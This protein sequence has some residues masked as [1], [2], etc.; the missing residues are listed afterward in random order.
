MYDPSGYLD[1][2]VNRLTIG[3]EAGAV[4]FPVRSPVRLLKR[5]QKMKRSLYHKVSQKLSHA[6]SR[7]LVHSS[8]PGRGCSPNL[9]G[10]QGCSGPSL[11]GRRGS[12]ETRFNPKVLVNKSLPP[13][14]PLNHS[15]L[16]HTR[17]FQTASRFVAPRRWKPS[18]EFQRA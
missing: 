12:P 3:V 18:F 16:D 4:L 2:T 13:E 15:L 8:S 6:L 7:T 1:L 9:Q 5:Q 14:H 17:T 11:G 10:Q